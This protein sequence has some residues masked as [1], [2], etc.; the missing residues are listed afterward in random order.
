MAKKPVRREGARNFFIVVVIQF[1]L[2]SC[3]ISSE[4]NFLNTGAEVE[5]KYAVYVLSSG[6]HT[7]III[8]VNNITRERIDAINFFKNYEYID[9]GWGDEG[10]Y[11]DHG[12][13]KFCLGIKA[14]AIPT[15]SVMRVEGFS[16]ILEDIIH[17]SDY[18]IQFDVT[19]TEL[20]ELCVYIDGSF[21]RD[22]NNRLIETLRKRK[23]EVIFFKSVYYYHIFN[24]CN[25]WAARG[26]Q[27]AGLNVS[28]FMVI[29]KDDLF[30][31]V[32]SNG[33]V[34]KKR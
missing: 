32:R 12:G 7:G 28:S 26:L 27:C 10:Y 20:T 19:E 6:I 31:E 14:V 13:D 22:K 29:T 4:K 21:R 34:L 3:V 9:F 1:L 11:Q 23:G 24:T 33:V 16:G 8:P 2:T 5:S 30:D 15:S 25:T 17:W 18:A